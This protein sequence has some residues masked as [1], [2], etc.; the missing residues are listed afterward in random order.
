MAS[1]K[2]KSDGAGAAD[3]TVP[4]ELEFFSGDLAKANKFF[5]DSF[6]W[7]VQEI[8]DFKMGFAKWGTPLTGMVRVKDDQLNEVFQT[9]TLYFTV[10]DFDKEVKRL[11]KLGA[12][13]FSEKK[14]VPN[15]G[16][17]GYIQAPGDLILGLW[18][19][20][21]SYKPQP[22]P[23]EK[24]PGSDLTVNFF[25]FVTSEADDA[26][27]FFKKAF[28]WTFNATPF[29]DEKYWYCRG[30]E[31]SFSVGLRLPEK[32]EKGSN[33]LPFVNVSSLDDTTKATLKN[34]AKKFFPKPRP[35]G[36]FGTAGYVTTPGNVVL[37]LWESNPAHHH[38]GGEKDGNGEKEEEEEEE[39]DASE[40]EKPAAKK[41][42]KRGRGAAAA[43]KP[44]KKPAKK[45]RKD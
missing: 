42:V 40:E 44:A 45:S 32:Q 17:W 13:V 41:G 3:V 26:I 7:D 11:T 23:N 43:A 36:E 4:S 21:P 28:G 10:P 12:K 34:G 18:S 37:G 1:K 15:M 38:G 29:G 22:K 27:A 33:I 2:K 30:D 25:E 5:R 14:E 35:Y 24:K 19:N 6:Q 16:S 9:A 39:E 8:P 31:K 20:D